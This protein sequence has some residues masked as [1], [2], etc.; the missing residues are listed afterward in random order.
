[1]IVDIEKGEKEFTIFPQKINGISF[2]VLQ[3]LQIYRKILYWHTE[4]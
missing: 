2:L 4:N 3:R 1:M